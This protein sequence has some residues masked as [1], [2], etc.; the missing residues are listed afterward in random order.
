MSPEHSTVT[1][2]ALAGAPLKD[3]S[4]RRIV[5]ATARAIAE[6]HNVELVSLEAADDRVTATLATHKLAAIGFI[7]ELRRLTTA[8]YQSD[9]PGQYLWGEQH[10]LSNP[11]TDDDPADWWKRS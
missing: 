8:W 3:Q 1:L 5:T 10:D 9:H 2:R 6:R 7:A 4:V 11:G